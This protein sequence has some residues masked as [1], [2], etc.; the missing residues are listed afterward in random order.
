MENRTWVDVGAPHFAAFSSVS[1][2]HP[3]APQNG[4]LPAQFFA[5]IQEIFKDLGKRAWK[6][7]NLRQS[8]ASN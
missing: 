8:S 7:G 5:H 2:K 1:N 4:T 3:D 6:D